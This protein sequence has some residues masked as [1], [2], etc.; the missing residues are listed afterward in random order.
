[1]SFRTIA[2]LALLLVVIGFLMPVT[3]HNG[4]KIAEV[5]MGKIANNTI[6]GLL[7]YLVFISAIVGVVIGVLMITGKGGFS[8]TIDWGVIAVCVISGLIVYF[9]AMTNN[10]FG[11]K[12]NLNNGA[13]F[14]LAGW[15]VSAGCQVFSFL[16]RE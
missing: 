13:Y 14:I 1:M 11:L 6:M 10:K 9:G 15:I 3:S 2:K 4:F 5:F 12:P 7:T 8:S 16:K